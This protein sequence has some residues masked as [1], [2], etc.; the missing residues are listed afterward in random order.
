MEEWDWV[1]VTL[2]ISLLLAADSIQS[3]V[4]SAVGKS[5]SFVLIYSEPC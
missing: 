4:F 5:T 3:Y 2:C 1:L